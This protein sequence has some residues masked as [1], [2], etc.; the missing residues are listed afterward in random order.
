MAGAP[1]G[2]A[3]GMGDRPRASVL[4]EDRYGAAMTVL[5][6][7]R[8]FQQAYVVDDIAEAAQRWNRLYGAGPFTVTPHHVA[9]RF[10]YRGTTQEADVSYAFGYLGETMIQFIEQHDDTPSIYR[11][12]YRRGESG[13]HHVA[14]LVH[15]YEAERSRMLEL[16]YELACELHNVGVDACYFDTRADTGGFTELHNDPPRILTAFASWRRAHE[17]WRPGDPVVT[18]RERPPA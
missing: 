9:E 16:G 4:I 6:T 3:V 18:V 7:H 8:H 10:T 1:G 2:P 5:T 14:V 17:L 11:E 13:F 15:D 12:M